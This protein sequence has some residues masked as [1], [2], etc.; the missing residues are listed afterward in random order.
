MTAQT[1]RR[2]FLQHS[3]E[4]AAALA[5]AAALGGVQSLG[6]EKPQA[7]RLGII[8]CGGI[9]THHVNGIVNRKV[10]VSIAWLCDVDPRQIDKM[11]ALLNG[12]QATAPKPTSKFEDV[13]ADKNVDAL[14]IPTT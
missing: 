12:F 7:I 2:D 1:T 9:M 11:A 3:S 8:G 4:A 6:A 5:A 10:P 14:I 13:I